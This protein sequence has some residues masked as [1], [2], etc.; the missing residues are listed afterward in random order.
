MQDQTS[1]REAMREIDQLERVVLHL[2]LENEHPGLWSEAE[3]ARA[4]GSELRAAHALVSLHAAGLIHRLEHFVFPT[5]PASRFRE[6]ED[7]GG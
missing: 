1:R 3:V 2:L 7:A 5:R 6:L 4:I